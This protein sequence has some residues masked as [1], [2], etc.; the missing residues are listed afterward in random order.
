MNVLTS[1]QLGKTYWALCHE[2]RKILPPSF[3]N[4]KQMWCQQGGV[5]TTK[6]VPQFVFCDDMKIPRY[7]SN[8]PILN[9]LIK[10]CLCGPSRDVVEASLDCTQKGAG[11]SRN[12]SMEHI[13]VFSDDHYFHRQNGCKDD[14]NMKTKL[15]HKHSNH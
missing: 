8:L 4:Q 3:E 15:Y 5:T 2:P 10:V 13:R 6:T 7:K 12:I 14:N 1:F 9:R 11:P